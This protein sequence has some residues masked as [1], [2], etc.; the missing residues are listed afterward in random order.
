MYDLRTPVAHSI[1]K[2]MRILTR[3]YTHISVLSEAEFYD[4]PG[5]GSGVRSDSTIKDQTRISGYRYYVRL[6][7][8]FR[9]LNVSTDGRRGERMRPLSWRS[10]ASILDGQ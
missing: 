8:P 1:S 7:S 3:V 2:L 4:I 10:A 6:L 5:R 9:M